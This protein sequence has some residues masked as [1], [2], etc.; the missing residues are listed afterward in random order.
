MSAS[1]SSS[2]VSTT[3][4]LCARARAAT[5]LLPMVR[6]S[7]AT[8]RPID[9]ADDSTVTSA[10]SATSRPPRPFV[11]QLEEKGTCADCQDHHQHIPAIGS[12]KTPRAL[13]IASPR[14]RAAGVRTLSTPAVAE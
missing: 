13:V 11:L 12:V 3:A 2:S 4:A 7:S 1:T 8:R 5:T 6:A 10:I 14:S 9:P